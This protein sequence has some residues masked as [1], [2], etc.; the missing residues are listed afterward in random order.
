MTTLRQFTRRD[1][2]RREG[3]GRSG[4]L[5]HFQRAQR[6]QRLRYH[7]RGLFALPTCRAAPTLGCKQANRRWAE[8]GAR[9]RPL[10]P[11]ASSRRPVSRG[12]RANCRLSSAWPG[13]ESVPCRS[14]ATRQ[15]NP[16]RIVMPLPCAE[17][18][19][20]R[21]IFAAPAARSPPRTT[22]GGPKAAH[23]EVVW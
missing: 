16:L 12:N 18:G 14:T 8:S 22:T 5:R 6:N 17:E 15:Q 13:V 9:A 23:C 3:R 20:Q 10:R 7:E 11:A 1:K 21:P 19:G 2:S 4:R